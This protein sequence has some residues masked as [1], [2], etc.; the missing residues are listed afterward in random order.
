MFERCAVTDRL[1]PETAAQRF[2]NDHFPHCRVAMV[3]SS[4]FRGEGTP[5]SDLDIV[6]VTD[7]PEA[8]IRASY[9]EHGWPIEVFVHTDESLRTYF[10]TDTRRCRPSLLSM[11]LEGVVLRDD[12]SAAH[13]K[14][15]ARALLERGP[16]PLTE[17]Q[18]EA[19]RYALTDVLDDFWG[20]ENHGEGIF[21]AVSLAEEAVDFIL[22]H[23][24]RWIGHGKWTQR[25]LHRFDPAVAERLT[26]ALDAYL[27]E[28]NKEPL[29][30]F[31]EEA[32]NLAGGRLFAGY[33]QGG[34][35]DNEECVG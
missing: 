21:I 30:S 4:V 15:E 20:T 5:T 3:A 13:I 10:D 34:Q 14:E 2:I 12:G 22:L 1:D 18:W 25:A 9:V 11:C 6:V 35:R 23:Y 32:L 28:N 19:H 7:A 33:R 24:G 8:P 29:A 26:A 16:Q 27:G 17:D 31:A